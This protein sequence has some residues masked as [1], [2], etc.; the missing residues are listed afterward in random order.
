MSVVRGKIPFHAS[1]V[2]MPGYGNS[3]IPNEEKIGRN[4]TAKSNKLKKG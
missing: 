1:V 4:L 3:V 2:E